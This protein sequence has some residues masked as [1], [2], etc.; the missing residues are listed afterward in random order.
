[1]SAST[2]AH[3]RLCNPQFAP[4]AAGALVTNTTGKKTAIRLIQLRNVTESAVTVKLYT[5]P[6]NAG[7]VGAASDV[8][9]FFGESLAAGQTREFEYAGQ[10]LYLDTAGDSL[11]VLASTGNAVACHVYGGQE[12]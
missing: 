10:G 1:M 9:S 4:A 3:K 6:G 5:V 8:H 7:A 12:G 11:Q 2:Y